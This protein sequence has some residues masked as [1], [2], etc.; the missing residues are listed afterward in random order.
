MKKNSLS[1]LTIIVAASLV[2]ASLVVGAFYVGLIPGSKPVVSSPSPTPQLEIDQILGKIDGVIE[3]PRGE[4]PS[5][6]TVTDPEKLEKQAFFAAAEVGDKVLL[7]TK[8]GRAVLYR[9][10]T[11]R[12]IEIGPFV[13]TNPSSNPLL[14][15]TPPSGS[16]K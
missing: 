4:V 1:T 9:P 16:T 11:G 7:Y 12:V 5:L 3:L 13:L 8:A 10:K 15:A 6:A 2:G 14:S